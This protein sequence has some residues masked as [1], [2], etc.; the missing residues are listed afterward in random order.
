VNDILTRQSNG[1]IAYWIERLHRNEP[2]AFEGLYKKCSGYVSFVCQKFCDNKEDAEEIVQDT[3]V[4]AFKKAQELRSETLLGY[5]R[6][7]AIHECFRRRKANSWHMANQAT[8]DEMLDTL[9]E[10]DKTILPED[11]LLN[12]EQQSQLLVEISKLPKNQREMVYLY[13]YMDFSVQQ[14][15]E[16]MSCSANSVYL[17]LKRARQSIKRKLEEGHAT[18]LAANALVLLPLGILFVAEEAAYVATYT[19]GAFVGANTVGTSVAAAG[20]ITS[21]GSIAGYVTAACAALIVLTAVNM[22]VVLSSTEEAAYAPPTV[23]A[24][25]DAPAPP[26]ATM[27]SP[28]TTPAQMEIIATPTQ[29]E[30]TAP[31]PPPT[32]P[33][34]PSPTLPPTSPSTQSE[35]PATTPLPTQPPTLPITSPPTQSETPA[36]TPSPTQ[37]PALPTTPAPTQPPPPAITDRTQA[38][39]AALS[40]AHTQTAVARILDDYD[41]AP[42]MSLSTMV[43][44][45]LNFFLFNEG[46]GDILVGTVTQADGSGWRIQYIFVDG[47]QAS[48]DSI[49]LF[50]WMN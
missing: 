10:L 37:P 21:S 33:P 47:G 36:T 43:G 17:V 28:A 23:V 30:T 48:I 42:A 12:K 39:L 5:L 41:F 35:T 11:A 26:P 50:N 27:P 1:E 34:A 49:D 15:A 3:F 38:V 31:T 8:M 18:I 40:Q 22:Y 14:I 25:T 9:P 19:P 20:T 45:Q 4:I 32:S 16:L 7:I 44:E 2:D 46:S 29:S 24:A 6:K 13:Y